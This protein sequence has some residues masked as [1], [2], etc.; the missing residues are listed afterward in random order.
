VYT[1]VE[2]GA[3]CHGKRPMDVPEE[4]NHPKLDVG[5]F[6]ASPRFVI[7]GLVRD[8]RQGKEILKQVQDDDLESMKWPYRTTR[9]YSFSI[10]Q[11]KI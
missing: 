9:L 8:L 3:T 4:K 1:K 5:S 11:V 7:P 2:L 6:C 10:V